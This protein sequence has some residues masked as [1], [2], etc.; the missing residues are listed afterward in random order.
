MKAP[1]LDSLLKQHPDLFGDLVQHKE[2]YH[3]QIIYTQIDRDSQNIP[4]FTQF[5]YGLD[6]NTYY[7][8][9][10]TVKLPIAIL[11]LQKLNE[12]NIP[13]LDKYSTMITEAA[14]SGQTP[15]Y[16]DPTSFQGA[17]SIAQYIRKIFLVSDNDAF[18]RLY[19]FLG[20]E[21]INNSLHR[22]G[23]DSAQ[24]LHRLDVSLSEDQNRHTNP[25][26]FYDS[27]TQLIYKKPLENSHYIYQPRYTVLGK[28]Y[29]KRGV[30]VNEPFDFSQKNR[31][32][33]RDLNSILTRVLFPESFPSDQ[34]FGLKDSDYRFLWE[35]MSR[36]PSES[37]YPS[38]DS[39][40]TDAYVKFLLYGGKGAIEDRNIRIFNKVGDAYGFL[41][42]AAYIVDFK[43]NIEFLLSATIYCNSDEIFNDDHYDYDTIGLPFLKN[44]GKVL[45]EYELRRQRQQ[46]PDLSRFRF[47]YQR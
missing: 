15:A 42:D 13:G 10:S 20:Q 19:E 22:L 35:C 6:S 46:V 17:P 8:P 39:S 5:E 23:M 1:F 7:Y 43:N 28:G 3:I 31:L 30:L 12:L 40:Y 2:H 14:Y 18:N 27:S 34:R 11:S 41:T 24:I 26:S 37:D 32:G 38:Y 4:H 29:Y 9:A 33:L 21:Y 47:N 25:V 16:N 44:L 45:Y 36:Y